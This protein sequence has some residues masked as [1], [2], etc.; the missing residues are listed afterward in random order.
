M[1][2]P[3]T[4][5][6]GQEASRGLHSTLG[7]NIS[8]DFIFALSSLSL[9]PFVLLSVTSPPVPLKVPNSAP[10][11]DLHHSVPCSSQ[12]SLC[13][14]VALSQGP[15]LRLLPPSGSD[16]LFVLLS[17]LLIFLLSVSSASIFHQQ[18]S[19]ESLLDARRSRAT[20]WVLCLPLPPCCWPCFP[21]AP[22][23]SCPPFP[24]A[25]Q[26]PTLVLFSFMRNPQ[27]YP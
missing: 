24:P 5:P 18:A 4:G 11:P 12:W 15:Q 10:G 22:A 9:C 14:S 17:L 26:A 6:W 19:I 20:F 2:Q 21:P 25:P 1:G 7:G 3:C 27:A 8:L 23:A 13:G 16:P